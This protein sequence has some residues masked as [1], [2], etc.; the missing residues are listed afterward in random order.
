MWKPVFRNTETVLIGLIDIYREQLI[1]Q[2]QSRFVV[3]SRLYN[4]VETDKLA[5]IQ[6]HTSLGF[7]MPDSRDMLAGIFS[8]IAREL[9]KDRR[10]VDKYL[11]GYKKPTTRHKGITI[12]WIWVITFTTDFSYS[13]CAINAAI[14]GVIFIDV[15]LLDNM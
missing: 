5:V 8:Q 1:C 9:G 7:L 12:V 3:R 4:W 6:S 11:K 2:S 14:S 13:S 10:T 15:L